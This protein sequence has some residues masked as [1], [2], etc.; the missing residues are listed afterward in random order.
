MKKVSNG[1]TKNSIKHGSF[2]I[3][4]K[5]I[6]IQ[7]RKNIFNLIQITSNKKLTLSHDRPTIYVPVVCHN[8]RVKAAVMQ[9]GASSYIHFYDIKWLTPVDS[10]VV[11]RQ[12]VQNKLSSS[13]TTESTSV[14][15]WRDQA[16]L[17]KAKP[18][19]PCHTLTGQAI[20]IFDSSLIKKWETKKFIYEYEK[21]IF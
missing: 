2:S 17:Q 6:S 18:G 7:W 5:L 19:W 1:K 3:T 11:S 12:W 8:N 20:N 21:L 15:S 10:T 14:M 16:Q 4:L 13:F 9:V